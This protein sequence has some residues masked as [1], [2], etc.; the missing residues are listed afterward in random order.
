MPFIIDNIERHIFLRA[1]QNFVDKRNAGN[2]VAVQHLSISLDVVLTAGEVP[3]E[4]APVHKV[5]LVGEEELQVFRECRFHY[6]LHLS[7]IVIFH[8]LAFYLRPFLIGLYMARIGA[9]HTREQHVQFVDIFVFLIGAGHEITV[10]LVFVFLD[11]AAPG[12]FA[13]CR[14]GYA[15]SS[16]VFALYFRNV[17]LPVEERNF[18]ILF[19]CQIGTQR[20]DIA[21]CVLVH[22]RVGRCTDQ[23]QCIRR[24]AYNDYHQADQDRI[25]RL[26]IHLL[27]LE[28]VKAQCRS[29]DDRQNITAT[30]KR[31][32]DQYDRQDESD[33][34]ACRMDLVAHSFP[35]RPDQHACHNDH[36]S[37][38]PGIVRHA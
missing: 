5:Q 9:V 24:I 21:R 7:A 10:F 32:T 13:F 30:D 16:L 33:L 12:R 17:G 31:N 19:T 6:A 35:D 36:I 26:D 3:H 22:R 28:Q 15:A 2:P 1:H 38:Y 8:R 20:K 11:H 27:A 37:E 4:V 18:T 25:Q 34:H 29:Q 14:D 23:C